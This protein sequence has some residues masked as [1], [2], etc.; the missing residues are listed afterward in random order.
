MCF[1]TRFSHNDKSRENNSKEGGTTAQERT[2]E[3]N[4]V[5]HTT[6][7]QEQVVDNKCTYLYK[8]QTVNLYSTSVEQPN[9]APFM[10]NICLLGPKGERIRVRALFDDGAMVS[11]MCSTV[12]NMI[13]HRL[14]NISNSTQRLRMAN[15][16]TLQSEATWT[17]TV[18]IDGVQTSSTFEVF[19]SKGGWAFLFGK[20]SLAAFKA[21]HDYGEDTIRI[22][23]NHREAMLENQVHTDRHRLIMGPKNT[24]DIK[25]R[26]QKKGG[27]NPPMRRV[28]PKLTAHITNIAN[29][30]PSTNTHKHENQEEKESGKITEQ[31]EKPKEE[32]CRDW[33]VSVGVSSISPT[34]PESPF[35]L[36]SSPPHP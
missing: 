29:H 19:N 3:D 27:E 12:F 20:P 26:E 18:D 4:N 6:H 9:T 23:D 11:A 34:F 1:W 28:T 22:R 10:H 8:D 30:T 15:G 2:S 13:K 5:H 14:H 31:G 25:Q 21:V 16:V 24:L 33:Y 32:H 17:G 35:T 36:I 7:T